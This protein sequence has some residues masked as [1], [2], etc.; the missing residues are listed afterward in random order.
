[1]KKEDPYFD[2]VDSSVNVK[3]NSLEYFIDNQD[4]SGD[5]VYHSSPGNILIYSF[6]HA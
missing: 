6:R 1:M 5:T 2:F 3:Y 4:I